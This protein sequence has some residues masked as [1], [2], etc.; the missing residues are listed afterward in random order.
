MPRPIKAVINTGALRRNLAVARRHAPRS[1]VLA[2]V[3]ADAYGHGVERAARALAEADGMALLEIERAVRLRENG[4]ARR[5]VLL[6]GLFEPREL[7]LADEHGLAIVIHCQEQLRMLDAA[8]AGARFDVLLKINTGMNRLGFT[9]PA[10]GEAI[11]ALKGHRAV[12][13]LTL[14]THFATADEARGVAWQMQAFDDIAAGHDLPR[15]L[16]NS[17]ALLRYPAT[18]CDW[19]RPG[20]MLYGCSPFAD[21]TAQSLGLEPVMTLTSEIVAVQ[22]LR[23]GDRVGYGGVFEATQRDAHRRRC[24]RI[25]RRLSAPRAGRHAA[26]GRRCTHRVRSVASRWI[27]CA[28]T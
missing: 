1:S 6:G 10:A 15:C 16:A 27:C 21:V 23:A 24:L 12:A 8:R 13:Q 28:S 7:A 25:C 4:Y 2:V 3:K 19:V 22:E 11:A 5:V 18:H 9:P 26:A 17:A 14:M 20:I